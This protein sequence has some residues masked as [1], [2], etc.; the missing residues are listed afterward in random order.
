MLDRLASNRRAI[1][2]WKTGAGTHNSKG[3]EI[4]VEYLKK[5]IGEKTKVKKYFIPEAH[6]KKVH[7]KNEVYSFKGSQ[8]FESGYDRF[9][10]D[11]KREEYPGEHS[12]KEDRRSD[13]GDSL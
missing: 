9:L 11:V 1:E 13:K 10:E 2:Y 12:I 4:G 8:L 6:L 7:P 3:E 5:L